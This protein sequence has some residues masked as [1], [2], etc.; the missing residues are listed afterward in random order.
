M[1]T[2]SSTSLDGY[3]VSLVTLRSGHC[4]AVLTD[5]GA[6]LL[7]LHVPDRDGNLAD[8]VLSRKTMGEVFE[9]RNYLGA[10]AGRY[11]GRIRM[12]RFSLDGR[13]YQLACNEGSNH[14]HGGTRGFD[15]YSWSTQVDP[16]GEA[17]TFVRVSPDGEEGFPGELAT[18]VTYRLDGNTL[19]IDMSATT[20]R[21]TIVRLVNHAY[22]NLAGHDSGTILDHVVHLNASHYIPLDE[23][24]LPTGEVLSVHGTP[25]DFT[26]PRPIGEENSKVPNNG[27]GRVAGESAGYDHIWVLDGTGDRV[28]GEIT[29]PVSG[30]RLEL[31]TNQR[32]LC[33][34]V[35][36]Y[37]GGVSA[38]GPSESYRAFAGLT[39]ETTGFPDDVNQSH[40]PSPILRPGETY[41]NSVR[42]TFSTV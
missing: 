28:V 14:L 27:A 40:F 4:T 22:W 16:D 17:V 24:L 30:R 12:G 34:Y 41:R 39:L 23:E 20:D 2:V 15:Q 35:G 19:H 3:P 10:T 7:E 38:K 5:L 25:F 21:P 32:G 8:V 29:D 9:D 1:A 33:F 37:L 13:D 11:A 31:A 36:G 18:R 42:L 6:R 26:K